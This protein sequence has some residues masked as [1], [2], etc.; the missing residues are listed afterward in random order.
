[1]EKAAMNQTSDASRIYHETAGA[2]G[3]LMSS[4]AV[5]TPP[6]AGTAAVDLSLGHT[7]MGMTA[8]ASSPAAAAPRA[9]TAPR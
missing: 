8:D 2:P 3:Q 6:R 9:S 4:S 1:M 5:P 7:R